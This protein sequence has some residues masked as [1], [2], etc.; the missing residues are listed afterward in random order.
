MTWM[1]LLF[2]RMNKLEFKRLKGLT[3]NLHPLPT[4]ARP[5][6]NLHLSALPKKKI[7]IALVEL[8]HTLTRAISHCWEKPTVQ[9]K[10]GT[11]WTRLWVIEKPCQLSQPCDIGDFR[12]ESVELP[13]MQHSQWIL[14]TVLSDWTKFDIYKWPK[15]SISLMIPHH[16]I[17]RN[18]M[19][20]S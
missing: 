4:T 14:P 8:W 19:W 7:F 11:W 15:K 20:C 5:Q 3:S 12:L 17:S 9:M 6:R 13:W 1:L 18:Q 16:C 2:H 10:S